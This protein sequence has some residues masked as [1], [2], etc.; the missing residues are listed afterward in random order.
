MIGPLIRRFL[1]EGRGATAV[2][3]GLLCA[4]LAGLLFISIEASGGRAM[5]IIGRVATAIS[6]V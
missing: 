6:G 5:S 1:G 3:Y 2:E 4:L